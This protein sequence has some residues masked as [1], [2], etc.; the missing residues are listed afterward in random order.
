VSILPAAGTET[1]V[2]LGVAVEVVKPC[3]IGCTV[4]CATSINKIQHR[5]FTATLMS[6][7]NYDSNCCKMQRLSQHISVL[8]QSPIG[9]ADREPFLQS[10]PPTRSRIPIIAAAISRRNTMEAIRKCT[11]NFFECMFC[12]RFFARC[13]EASSPLLYECLSPTRDQS[14]ANPRNRFGHEL[15][16]SMAVVLSFL[17]IMNRIT[18]HR[19]E[20]AVSILRR[21]SAS[22]RRLARFSH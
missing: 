21:P 2:A 5:T 4:M 14:L 19:W 20:Q 11:V 7:A 9:A 6:A 15:R 16:F 8:L 22:T 13:Q 12:L 3:N 1:E 18:K 17:R 10:P